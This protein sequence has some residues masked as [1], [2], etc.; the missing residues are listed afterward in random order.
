MMD[1]VSL[2]I[3]EILRE[4]GADLQPAVHDLQ[5]RV[6]SLS[7]IEY[8]QKRK[9][10]AVEYGIR[11]SALDKLRRKP[12]AQRQGQALAIDDPVPAPEPQDGAVLLDDLAAQIRR[13]IAADTGSID[14]MALWTVFAHIAGGAAVCPNLAFVSATK[15]CGKS[16]ALD[17]VS[18]LIPRSINIANITS[19]SLFRAVEAA[20]PSL[21]IDEADTMFKQNDELRCLLNAGFTRSAAQVLRT[22]GDDYEPRVFTVWAAK[23][24]ALIGRLPDTLESRSVVIRMR[25]R[26]PDE[27]IER[28]R[29]DKDQ[30]FAE[31]QSRIARF[32]IDNDK[33]ILADEPELPETLSDRQADV[34]RELCRIADIAGGDWPKRARHIALEFCA[35]SDDDGDLSIQ[36]LADIQTI[37]AGSPERDFWPSQAIVDAL[38]GLDEAPWADMNNGK[39]LTTNRLARM[40]QRFEIHTKTVRM[41]DRTPKGY[42]PA[43][44]ADIFARFLQNNCNTATNNDKSM[45]NKDLKCCRNVA[46]ADGNRNIQQ[47][48]RD[49][50]NTESDE[51]SSTGAAG[52]LDDLDIF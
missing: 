45:Q 38:N 39:G 5:E 27:A 48:K 34:W 8:E 20:H 14:A 18:R 36:L 52:G 7:E 22:V 51:G 32:I 9:D 12:G 4:I 16:T 10:L 15:A 30:G 49:D 41:G 21:I 29:S 23:A 44:F 43:S 13:F 31:L 24:F 1:G 50:A 3:G 37:F 6:N 47:A 19:T 42:V 40:L 33:A 17:V 35:K 28:L 25:R 2:P 11:V 46:V 26:L